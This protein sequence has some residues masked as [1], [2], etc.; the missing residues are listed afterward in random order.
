MQCTLKGVIDLVGSFS[1]ENKKF[2]QNT[3]S[4]I[5]SSRAFGATHIAFN[6]ALLSLQG[7]FGKG[8]NLC[9]IEDSPSIFLVM[10]R[11]SPVEDDLLDVLLNA[12]HIFFCEINPKDSNALDSSL[13]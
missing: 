5:R 1:I 6:G 7:D 4:F 8:E 10:I 11:Q 12:A 13:V 9:F 3:V 2:Y